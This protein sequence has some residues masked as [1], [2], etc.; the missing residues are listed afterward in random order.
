MRTGLLFVPFALLL[1]A[2]SRLAERERLV[3]ESM[4]NRGIRDSAVLRAMRDTP[5]H[6][7]MPQH[8][9]RYAYEDRPVPIGYD[10]T[11]SQPSLVAFMTESLDV[12]RNH[13]VLEIGT[14][15]GY[16][17]A[18][19]AAVAKEVYTI[20]IVPELA[21]SSSETLKRLGY[22]NVSTREG[23]GYLGWPE[24]AP[25]DRIILTAAPPELPQALVDQLKPGGK[26]IAPVGR[27]SEEQEL[28]LVEKSKSGKVKRRSILLVRFVP[29]VQHPATQ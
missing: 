24:H 9:R 14:G 11:I 13:R 6:E 15:S 21:R 4:E 23:N 28:M 8:V 1:A 25:F 17:A 26:L 20:E 27:T 2:D 5:R 7:F 3:S 18:V 19:L 12:N 10:Q 16:Q 29:M 22:K